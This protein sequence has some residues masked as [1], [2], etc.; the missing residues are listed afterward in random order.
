MSKFKK[1]VNKILFERC[2]SIWL[3]L[4]YIPG[5][6]VPSIEIFRNPS[7]SEYLKILKNTSA[8]RGFADT[9]EVIL[10][11]GEKEIHE[12]VQLAMLRDYE[13]DNFSGEPNKVAKFQV[14]GDKN[15]LLAFE[16]NAVA[17]S[18][19]KELDNLKKMLLNN[20]NFTKLFSKEEILA[21]DSHHFVDDFD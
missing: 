20:H 14:F 6:S 10:W 19:G 18:H 4:R 15:N 13:N 1:L 5:A 7:K 21:A 12:P 8:I 3:D 11:D 17:L 9:D 16:D 2:E